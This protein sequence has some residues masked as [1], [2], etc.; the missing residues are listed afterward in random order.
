[1]ADGRALNHY[2]TYVSWLPWC[3]EWVNMP[4]NKLLLECELVESSRVESSL[5]L[6]VYVFS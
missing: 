2:C 1:M 6:S 5:I 3:C 4:C